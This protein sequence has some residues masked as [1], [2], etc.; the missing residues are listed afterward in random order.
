MSRPH[1]HRHAL[2]RLLCAAALCA[3]VSVAGHAAADYP[4][5]PLRF[6]VPFAPGGGNDTVARLVGQRLTAILGQ[7]VVVDN[8]AGA[9]GI[10]G[11]ELAA[12]AAP[13]GYTLFLGGVGSHAINPNLHEHLSYDPI[14]DFAPV[15]LLA[16]APMVLVVHPSVKATSVAE[17]IA[18]A[19]ANPGKLNY[20]SN[21]NGSSSHLAAV[22]FDSMAGVDMVHIPYKGLS[23]ALTDLLAGQVQVMFSSVVAILP[24]IQ[25]GKLR[26]LAVSGNR[27]LSLLPDLPTIAEAGVPGY[28]ASSWYGIL[29]PAGTP[30]DVVAKLN[31]AILRV[32]A[33]P[34][35]K[36]AFASEGADP[37]GNSP[38]AFALFIAAEK[39]RLGTLIRQSKIHLQ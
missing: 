33:E 2:W 31:A 26:A 12:K 28:Q 17:L 7:P 24:H 4:D 36:K 22:M 29:A 32:L 19:R 34:D 27:R 8:R 21:G 35:V 16:S 30:K 37:V 3:L 25:A 6:I 15:S 39:D 13:D 10:V 14:R 5:R 38:E 9:G 23:P 18:L 1:A 11:A 20:A